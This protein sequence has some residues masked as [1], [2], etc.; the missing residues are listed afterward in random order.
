MRR[1]VSCCRRPARA[2]CPTALSAILSNACWSYRC[3]AFSPDRGMSAAMLASMTCCNKPAEGSAVLGNQSLQNSYNG[4]FNTLCQLQGKAQVRVE[5]HLTCKPVAAQAGNTTTCHVPV[6][7]EMYGWILAR[8]NPTLRR[9]SA[10]W[11]V[12]AIS[13]F[14]TSK[15]EERVVLLEHFHQGSIAIALPGIIVPGCEFCSMCS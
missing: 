3:K 4:A 2:L 15:A 1:N 12:F 5:K 14:D 10:L 6:G 8:N 11:R 9:T 13:H 7:D